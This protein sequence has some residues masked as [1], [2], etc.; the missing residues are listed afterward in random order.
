MNFYANIGIYLFKVS[1][2]INET[3]QKGFQRICHTFTY[4]DENMFLTCYKSLVCTVLEAGTKRTVK[5]CKLW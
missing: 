4:M 5:R 3:C 1:D 2:N